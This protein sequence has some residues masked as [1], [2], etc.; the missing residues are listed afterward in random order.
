MGRA[1]GFLFFIIYFQKGHSAISGIHY[2][3]CD[4]DRSHCCT[5]RD[6]TL[7]AFDRSLFWTTITFFSL[8]N[9]ICRNRNHISNK[10]V[11]VFHS[12]HEDYDS[13]V[14]ESVHF[15][16]RHVFVIKISHKKVIVEIR[17]TLCV[18]ILVP[19]RDLWQIQFTCVSVCP[20]LLHAK[21]RPRN[22]KL[23]KLVN[24]LLHF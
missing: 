15:S 9:L 7:D 24:V 19:Y 11:D 4:I 16:F 18:T 17:K 5:L 13:G 20:F 8:Q 12:P 3:Q 22:G 21:F 2:I 10:E 6:S 14:I 23:K 1:G